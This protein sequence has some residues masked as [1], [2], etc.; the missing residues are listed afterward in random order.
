MTY[1]TIPW[2]DDLDWK[3]SSR[4]RDVFLTGTGSFPAV[5]CV[6]RRVGRRGFFKILPIGHGVTSSHSQRVQLLPA[7]LG[8]SFVGPDFSKTGVAAPRIAVPPVPCVMRLGQSPVSL[9]GQQRRFSSKEVF[10]LKL[11][12]CSLTAKRTLSSGVPI[13]SLV[14]VEF[15]NEKGKRIVRTFRFGNLSLVDAVMLPVWSETS[16]PLGD[17]EGF[18]F[19]LNTGAGHGLRVVYVSLNSRSDRIEVG[20]DSSTYVANSPMPDI[21]FDENGNPVLRTMMPD[22]TGV[23]KY[24]FTKFAWSTKLNG[25]VKISAENSEPGTG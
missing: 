10:S 15:R 8:S 7:R 9:S 11:P 1:S 22:D 18:L 20:L 17:R 16:D 2:V 25:F 4:G 21:S 12:D 19:T 13:G 6:F 14:T 24:V 3:I 23:R 5:R